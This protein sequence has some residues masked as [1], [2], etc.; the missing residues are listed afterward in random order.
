MFKDGRDGNFSP[1]AST[2][3]KEAAHFILRCDTHVQI[4]KT[5][6][7]ASCKE[8]KLQDKNQAL[9]VVEIALAMMLRETEGELTID[10]THRE[11][12]ELVD[13]E[14]RVQRIQPARKLSM[15]EPYG[16]QHTYKDHAQIA[17][18]GSTRCDLCGHVRRPILIRLTPS[19]GIRES[20]RLR[21]VQ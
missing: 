10:T 15:I 18:H 7:F 5:A 19:S 6:R 1:Q 21:V 8:P 14:Q 16:V 17:R 2:Q 9:I 11:E 4:P 13:G 20:E 12:N 3:S